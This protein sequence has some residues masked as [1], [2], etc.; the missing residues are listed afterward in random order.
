MFKGLLTFAALAAVAVVGVA[1]YAPP[2]HPSITPERVEFTSK[3]EKVIG[4]LYRPANLPADAKPPVVVIAPPWLNVKEQVATR[5]A[6]AMAQRGVAALAIDFRYWGESGGKVRELESASAKADDLDA[7]IAFLKS[8]K[9]TDPNRIGLLGICF[10]A[11]H[12]FTVARR[13][14]DVRSV[15]TV[16]AW[17]NDRPALVKLFGQEWIDQRAKVAA[18]ARATF[19]RTG[20]VLYVPA[21]SN[22]D[23]NAGMCV[24]D[25]NFYYTNPKRGQ[26]AGWTNRM[27]VMSWTEWLEL[28]GVAAA[29]KVSQPLLVVHSDGCG[30][31]DNA[32]AALAAAKG[33][34]DLF[35]SEGEHTQF[36]D[37]E[38]HV[39]KAADAVA[40]HFKRTLGN[41]GANT[42]ATDEAAIIA[43]VN[44]VGSLADARKWP[45]L[46]AVFADNVDVDYTSLVGG[47]PSRVKA[48]ELIA[49]WEKGLGAFAKTEHVV[50]GHQVTVNGDTADCRARFIATHTRGTPDSTDRWTCG[51][52]YRYTLTKVNGQWKVSGTVMTLEWEQGKR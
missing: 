13:N 11:G 9:D 27:A 19:E 30:L 40:G 39:S 45:D 34:K 6:E 42:I 16:A 2:A 4:L 32:R 3:G 31:P 26:V 22:T 41:V 33:P 36:Y 37:S 24:P 52:R 10:G 28:D 7:A 50:S 20:E 18:E 25:P 48:D 44:A 29:G 46:R 21:A 5:W 47:Q 43:A 1:M 35:W 15:A 38:P 14:T 51:G 17:L 8:R 49:G 12:A 23:T